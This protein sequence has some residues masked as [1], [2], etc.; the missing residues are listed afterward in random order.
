MLGHDGQECLRLG[1]FVGHLVFHPEHVKYVLQENHKNYDKQTR[2][3]DTIRL[4]IIWKGLEP[5]PG[6]YDERYLASMARG[7][8]VLWWPS[9]SV[10]TSIPSTRT[11]TRREPR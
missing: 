4:G 1:P 3:F 10:R 6:Q 7:G 8:C 11:R 2:G 9:S 5:R